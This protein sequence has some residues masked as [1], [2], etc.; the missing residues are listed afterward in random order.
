MISGA[1]KGSQVSS[2]GTTKDEDAETFEKTKAKNSK[3]KEI[4]K[5]FFVHEVCG[6][7]SSIA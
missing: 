3:T 5:S 1:Q 7:E 4:N 6:D 2:T